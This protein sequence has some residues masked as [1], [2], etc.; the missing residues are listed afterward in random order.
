MGVREKRNEV[1]EKTV[2]WSS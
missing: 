2:Q 1:Q